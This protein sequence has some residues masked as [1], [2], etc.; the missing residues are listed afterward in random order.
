M[1]RMAPGHVLV[2]GLDVQQVED[3]L[4][5]SH[6]ED[7][8]EQ[9]FDRGDAAQQGDAAENAGRDHV[10]LQPRPTLAVRSSCGTTG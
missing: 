6:D 1:I 10:Q 2:E 4:D 3:V 8:R 9:P 5:R 7:A